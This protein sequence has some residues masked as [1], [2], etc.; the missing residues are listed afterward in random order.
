[1]NQDIKALTPADGINPT[2]LLYTVIAQSDSI[3]RECSKDGTT[4]ASIDVNRL[5][6]WPI[7]L[8][9][10]S[11]QAL[12]V[13]AIR[14]YDADLNA[15]IADC[16][17]ARKLLGQLRQR[18]IVDAMAPHRTQKL[19]ALVTGMKYGTSVKCTTDAEG[20]TVLRIPNVRRGVLDRGD[21]KRSTVAADQLGDSFVT[22]GD[23]LVIR[24][25]GS[26]DLIGRAAA[27]HLDD[28]TEALAFASYLIRLRPDL[29]VLDPSWLVMALSSP[30]VRIEIEAAAASSAGQR[31]RRLH[32]GARYLEL[33]PKARSSTP[34]MLPNLHPNSF[35]GS[36]RSSER[37][38]SRAGEG[39]TD[40]P[41]VELSHDAGHVRALTPARPEALELLHR[42][43]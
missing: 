25:N 41:C 19:G 22:D 29:D 30:A 5:G 26:R 37:S 12:I 13:D 15:A 8:P 2:W 16:G 10:S 20:P 9:P 27:V 35:R 4:V 23:V 39:S 3:R 11:T 17:V 14:R 6:S 31:S 32:S 40:R 18:T 28:S 1:V 42:P 43:P 38:R 24:T 33:R 34:R 36:A 7:A 21:L